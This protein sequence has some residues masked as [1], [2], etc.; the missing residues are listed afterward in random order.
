MT[1]LLSVEVLATGLLDMRVTTDFLSRPAA[2][3]TLAI[4]TDL[5]AI[6]EPAFFFSA[7]V[8]FL[9]RVL[10]TANC[11]DDRVDGRREATGRS[12]L[13]PVGSLTA[14]GGS[15]ALPIASSI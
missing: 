5:V 2:L 3:A 13:S 7:V 1:L 15:A 12:T 6:S 4:L 8:R 14:I 9:L 11:G 10:A